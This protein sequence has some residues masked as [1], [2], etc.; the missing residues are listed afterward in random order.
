VRR[1]YFDPQECGFDIE[2]NCDWIDVPPPAGGD[3][4]ACGADLYN[5][6]VINVN[7]IMVVLD[8]WDRNTVCEPTYECIDLNN[9]P[10]GMGG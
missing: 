8:N 10:A 7:D 3:G 4:I 9:L 6:S 5:D 1:V 2:S